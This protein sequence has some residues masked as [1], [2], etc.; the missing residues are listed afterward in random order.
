ML[1]LWLSKDEITKLRAELRNK[2]EK[3]EKARIDTAVK[4]TRRNVENI[5]RN[6]ENAELKA[7]IAKLEEDSRYSQKD[8]SP[9]KPANISDS[10][11]ANETVSAN[12]KLTEEKAMDFFLDKVNK[13]RV[14]DG[15]RFP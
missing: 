12:S 9:E 1:D 11:V 5:R 13:K 6:A 3:L 7:K 10:I 8:S 15:I 14:S 2:I 4:N